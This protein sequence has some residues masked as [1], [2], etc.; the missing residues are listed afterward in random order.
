MYHHPLK[1][2][3]PNTTPMVHHAQSCSFFNHLSSL[4][5]SLN[6]NARK[7]NIFTP[8]RLKII[9]NSLSHTGADA[10]LDMR[11][12]SLARALYLIRNWRYCHNEQNRVRL[13]NDSYLKSDFSICQMRYA[14]HVIIVTNKRGSSSYRLFFSRRYLVV[15]T[16]EYTINIH[17]RIHGIGFKYRAPR[18]IKEIKK[19]ATKTMGTPDVRIDTR[20]NKHVWHKGVKNVPFRIRVRL[21]RKRN[22]DEDSTNKLYT[23]VTVVEGI[24]S[25]KGL[26]TQ[27]VDVDERYSTLLIPPYHVLEMVL[28]LLLPFHTEMV[29]I[30]LLALLDVGCEAA[31]AIWAVNA[32]GGAHRGVDGVVYG[33]DPSNMPG[34][35]SDHG[36]HHLPLLARVHP[37]DRILYQ[38]ERYNFDTFGYTIPVPQDG[39]Y[40]LVLKF[41]EVYFQ[42]SNQKAGHGTAHD[43]YVPFRIQGDA[44][45]IRDYKL[46]FTGDV[47]VE[48]VKTPYD[49]PKINAIV[50]YEGKLAEVPKLPPLKKE[51]DEIVQEELI[52]EEP[53]RS[54]EMETD[55]SVWQGFVCG[56]FHRS[57][58]KAS[59]YD[60]EDTQY[61]PILIGIGVFLP[62]VIL[63]CK[64]IMVYG[65][66]GGRIAVRRCSHFSL[67]RT[68][69]T[70]ERTAPILMKLGQNSL[71]CLIRSEKN[72]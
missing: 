46:A 57:G 53:T 23:L 29:L 59:P 69:T 41:C 52:Q 60:E 58:L 55:V 39:D 2:S 21:A 10:L 38:T 17:K 72:F 44:L 47:Q 16:R 68:I 61:W 66:G 50:L 43:E 12:R 56:F 32:G 6:C 3:P 9:H 11:C 40:V 27:N 31:R 45:F 63:L 20:L 19:F 51:Q 64:S 25:F 22:E 54:E 65:V 42:A 5:L 35:T 18:A 30:L 1:T 70:Q 26:Q 8:P 4:V 28:I 49:N 67:R 14:G 13:K 34:V 36:I 15:V 24:E 62:T 48:F 7:I 71:W 37:Q 33:A